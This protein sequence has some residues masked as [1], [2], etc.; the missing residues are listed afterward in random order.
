[1]DFVN[2]RKVF[3]RILQIIHAKNVIFHAKAALVLVKRNV[4]LARL[5]PT[6][7]WIPIPMNVC[8]IF[9]TISKDHLLVDNV[10]LPVE[11]VSRIAK[12]VVIF[13]L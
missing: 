9:N 2:V 4:N 12:T 6:D 3:M 7:I 11:F 13:A 5:I 10:I 1:M 8:A